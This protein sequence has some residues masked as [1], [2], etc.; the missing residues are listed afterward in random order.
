[1]LFLV[2]YWAAG[3]YV[4]YGVPALMLLAFIAGVVVFWRNGRTDVALREIARLIERDN[5]KLNTLLLAAAEQQ[6]EDA[7]RAKKART[8]RF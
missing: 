3:V 1:M 5:P 4:P 7:A 6:L 2:G 8:A